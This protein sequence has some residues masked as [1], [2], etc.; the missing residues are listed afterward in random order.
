MAADVLSHKKMGEGFYTLIVIL[1][2]LHI[3][4]HLYRKIDL[5]CHH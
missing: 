1:T 5:N 4:L 2:I 3:Q